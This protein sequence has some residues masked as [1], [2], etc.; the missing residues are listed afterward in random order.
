MPMPDEIAE[1]VHLYRAGDAEQSRQKLRAY[2]NADVN[3][4]QA[5]LWLAKV[6]PAERE[7]TSAAELA[8]ALNPQDEVAQ[9]GVAAVSQ[10]FAGKDRETPA[11]LDVMR[12]TGMTFAQARRVIWSFKYRHI[13]QNW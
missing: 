3:T 6:S 12:L 8:L 4:R 2:L 13:E 9:R 7:A 11:P 10:R 1:A 5:M